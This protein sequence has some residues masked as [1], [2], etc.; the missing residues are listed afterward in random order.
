MEG[1]APRCVV[2]IEVETVFFQCARALLRSELWNPA[3][4][5]APEDL[6]TPGQILEALSNGTCGGET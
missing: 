5:V 6:P 4:F 3:K 1:K 2:V